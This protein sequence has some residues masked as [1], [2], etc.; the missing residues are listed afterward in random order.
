M[1]GVVFVAMR[2][3]R[4]EAGR[5]VEQQ[6][7]LLAD[8]EKLYEVTKLERDSLRAEVE[9]LE[10]RV[11]GLEDALLAQQ[12][13]LRIHVQRLRHRAEILAAS[14][15]TGDPVIGVELARLTD[16]IRDIDGMLNA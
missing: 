6:T 8:M 12:G 4:E 14:L 10:E 13:H 5:I 3:N 7:R 11:R 2:F 16:D 15:N 1:S 9:H